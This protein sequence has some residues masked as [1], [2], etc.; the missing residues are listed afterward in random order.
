MDRLIVKEVYFQNNIFQNLFSSLDIQLNLIDHYQEPDLDTQIMKISLAYRIL[1]QF[2]IYLEEYVIQYKIANETFISLV[3]SFQSFIK[4]IQMLN[5]QLC[6]GTYFSFKILE[7]S[8][9]T[10]EKVLIKSIIKNFKFK[11]LNYFENWELDNFDLD[12]I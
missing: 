6:K 4:Q 11:I 7:S 9:V 12:F 2:L 8:A 10:F 3:N 5:N 1:R